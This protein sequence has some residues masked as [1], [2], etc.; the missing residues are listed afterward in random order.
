MQNLSDQYSL[1]AIQG[2]MAAKAMQSLTDIDLSNMTYYTFQYGTFA[3]IENV[4]VSATGYTG[5]G[6]FEVYVKNEHAEKLW[7]AV[8]QAGESFKIK[9]IG[10]AAR[11][12]LRLEMGFC[13]YGNDIDDTSSPLEAGL[14]WITKF[15]KDFIDADFLKNQKETG[16]TRKLIAFEMLDRGIPRHDYPIVDQAGHQIGKV[17]SGTMSPSL[18][19]GIGLGYVQIDHAAL[20]TEIFISIRD[21]GIKAKVVKLPFYKK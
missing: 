7:N 16:L 8:F 3:G 19:I 2:P 6:G 15:T 4:M 9:P 5:S 13:L 1:L 18:K 11:D 20:D 21:K 10:L 14:G 17:T 12:T